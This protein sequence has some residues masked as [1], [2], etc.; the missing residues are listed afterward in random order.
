MKCQALFSQKKINQTWNAVCWCCDWWLKGLYIA[1]EKKADCIIV[2]KIIFFFFFFFFFSDWHIIKSFNKR[3]SNVKDA[4][5]RE[6]T[7]NWKY[8]PPFPKEN[9]LKGKNHSFES[10]YMYFPFSRFPFLLEWSPF[11][12]GDK[13]CHSRILSLKCVSIHL[14]SYHYLTTLWVNSEDNKLVIF[15]LFFFQKTEF[16]LSCTLSPMEI[17]CMKYQIL[18]SRKNKTIFQNGICWKC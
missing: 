9:T 8:L 14:N 5:S 3:W 11:E 7:L 16:D 13:H 17:I 4:H 12:K 10:N 18:L 1:R 6:I 2:K 15:F